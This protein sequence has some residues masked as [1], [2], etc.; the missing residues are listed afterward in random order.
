MFPMD[1]FPFTY[2]TTSDALTGKTDGLFRRCSISKTCPK[3]IHTDT[4]TELYQSRGS[5]IPSPIMTARSGFR[6]TSV[7]DGGA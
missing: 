1:E 2:G 4:Q 5:L 3:V 7:N 6:G